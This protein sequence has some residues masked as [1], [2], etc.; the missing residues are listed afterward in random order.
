MHR[1]KPKKISISLHKVDEFSH[2]KIAYIIE[3]F[4]AFVTFFT[5]VKLGTNLH[6]MLKKLLK[7]KKE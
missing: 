3:C 6:T 5:I 2:E 7:F 4:N 1:R